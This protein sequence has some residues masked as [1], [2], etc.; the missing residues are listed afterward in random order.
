L[1]EKIFQEWSARRLRGVQRVASKN[2]ICK[3]MGMR[4]VRSTVQRLKVYLIVFVLCGG[5][6]F[7]GVDDQSRSLAYSILLNMFWTKEG[8]KLSAARQ[9]P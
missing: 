6:S 5:D 1:V 2:V 7:V 3:L 9:S 4:V 8:G